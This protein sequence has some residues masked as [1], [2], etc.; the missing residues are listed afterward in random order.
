MIS[1][2]PL[3]RFIDFEY[4]KEKTFAKT[5]KNYENYDRFSLQKSLLLK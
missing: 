4:L 3:S 2:E 1:P 5:S